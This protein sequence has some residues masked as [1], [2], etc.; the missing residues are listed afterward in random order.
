MGL[1]MDG[2]AAYLWALGRSSVRG[3]RSP[4]AMSIRGSWLPTRDGAL[5]EHGYERIGGPQTDSAFQSRRA[6]G[7]AGCRRYVGVGFVAS[8]D[9]VPGIDSIF[10]AHAFT[11]I[12][13]W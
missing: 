4:L 5:R 10:V 3:Q 7:V 9:C 13:G 8:R 2:P 12:G 1:S 11:F 6:H